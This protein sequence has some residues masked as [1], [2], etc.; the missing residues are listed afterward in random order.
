[1]HVSGALMGLVTTYA[2]LCENHLD[3]EKDYHKCLLHR[4]PFLMVNPTDLFIEKIPVSFFHLTTQLWM[5]EFQSCFG[6]CIFL[7]IVKN[8][9]V[10][11]ICY[12][13]LCAIFIKLNHLF[14]SWLNSLLP[15]KTLQMYL[16]KYKHI[17]LDI[18][19][20]SIWEYC[21]LCSNGSCVYV[22]V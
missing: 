15:Y 18:Y 5:L 10:L 6:G 14:F 8:M 4:H 2:H 12:P 11:T 16:I 7:H 22:L 19:I 17:L 9:P 21:N 1:M 13:L 3:Q 20:L